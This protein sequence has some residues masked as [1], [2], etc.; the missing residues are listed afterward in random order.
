V[1][2]AWLD[3]GLRPR[4]PAPPASGGSARHPSPRLVVVARGQARLKAEIEALFR[5]DAGIRVI[6]NRRR[7]RALLPRPSQDAPTAASRW[8]SLTADARR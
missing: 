2:S 8:I 6:V 7:D 4:P 3:G 5:D 1:I